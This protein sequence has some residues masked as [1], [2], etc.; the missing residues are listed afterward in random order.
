VWDYYC[1]QQNVPV[2]MAWLD[3]V[4][5]YEQTVSAK[6]LSNKGNP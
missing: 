3:E 5:T 4:K 6:R 2:G 1:L